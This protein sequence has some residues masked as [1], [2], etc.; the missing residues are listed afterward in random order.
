MNR[1]L[2]F[3]GGLLAGIV[4][5]A[6]VAL[7]VAEGARMSSDT[8]Q[9]QWPAGRK[10]DRKVLGKVS[11]IKPESGGLFG[12][13]RSPSMGDSL[14][15]AQ[16]VGFDVIAGDSGKFKLRMPLL[17]LHGAKKGTIAGIGIVDGEYLICFAPAPAGVSEAELGTWLKKLD[18]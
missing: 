4:V 9:W 6:V 8:L 1:R 17:E 11:S 3:A 16:I 2:S 13:G 14:P 15:D 18:C 10:A 7:S 12:I 5:T